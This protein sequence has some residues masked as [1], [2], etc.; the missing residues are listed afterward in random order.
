MDDQKAFASSMDDQKSLSSSMD[1]QQTLASS[2]DE[3]QAFFQSMDGQQIFSSSLD[4]QQEHVFQ[5]YDKSWF[6][7]ADPCGKEFELPN[8]SNPMNLDWSGIS[9]NMLIST[10]QGLDIPFVLDNTFVLES[11]FSTGNRLA[12][13]P[14]IEMV[15]SVTNTV[16]VVDQK[17][18]TFNST[19]NY[20]VE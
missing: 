17:R 8:I 3:Q 15:P 6:D 4:D 13:L 5:Q 19:K 18:G 20:S 16:S 12:S 2:V 7:L 10:F 14:T 11:P 9:N 1:D